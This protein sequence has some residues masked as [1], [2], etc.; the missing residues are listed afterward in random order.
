VRTRAVIF[1]NIVYKKIEGGG[2][3]SAVVCVFDR[4]AVR[5]GFVTGVV[6]CEI[7]PYCTER[8]ESLARLP[9]AV[10]LLK[11]LSCVDTCHLAGAMRHYK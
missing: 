9:A 11:H 2:V 7:A 4:A 10:W 3:L 8:D 1:G 5:V 6:S